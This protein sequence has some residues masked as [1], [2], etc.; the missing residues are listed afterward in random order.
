MLLK[1]LL[2]TAGKYEISGS[3]EIEIN[4]IE[5][6]SRKIKDGNAFIA[7]RG[8]QADGHDYISKAIELGAKAII[9]EKL[10]ETDRKSV[11]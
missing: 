5:I 4:G 2:Q 1:E 10:P 9:C 3:D 11:V 7:I 6:D 8:T